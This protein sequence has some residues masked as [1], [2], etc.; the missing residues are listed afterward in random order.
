MCGS[1]LRPVQ[2]ETRLATLQVRNKP[3][4]APKS[5][6]ARSKLLTLNVVMEGVHVEIFR[7]FV[8]FYT[9]VLQRFSM[10]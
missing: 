7:F 9:A 1:A 4:P 3:V 10:V 2:Q 6:K 5:G 8:L